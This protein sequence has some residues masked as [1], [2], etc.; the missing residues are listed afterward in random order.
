MIRLNDILFYFRYV[1]QS[2][3]R[4]VLEEIWRG[5]IRKVFKY[6][7]TLIGLNFT[8][9]VNS[10]IMTAGSADLYIPEKMTGGCC[11]SESDDVTSLP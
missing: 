4:D 9:Q 7:E 3:C 6:V 11:L 1:N 2:Q 5:L 8:F 10:L